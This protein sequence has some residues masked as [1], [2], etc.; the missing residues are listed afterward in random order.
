MVSADMVD[1]TMI[2]AT[3]GI[4]LCSTSCRMK[5]EQ[6]EHARL[7]K[8]RSHENEFDITD[9]KGP[10]RFR[11]LVDNHKL[12]PRKDASHALDS[13]RRDR[14]KYSGPLFWQHRYP[15]PGR[16]NHRTVVEDRRRSVPDSRRRARRPGVRRGLVLCLVAALRDERAYFADFF[17][18]ALPPTAAA[19][20]FFV[21]SALIR[22][23]MPCC[24]TMASNSER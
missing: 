11:Q 2:P 15:R 18:A 13:I 17:S 12:M 1:G 23:S 3:I 5:L 14:R 21:A 9:L 4:Y 7:V 10:F 8:L 24:L 19:G 22:P 16:R 20:M 6:I